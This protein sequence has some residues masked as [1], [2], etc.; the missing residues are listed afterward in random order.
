MFYFDV[1]CIQHILPVLGINEHRLCHAQWPS[2][3]L[4]D[5]SKSH[6]KWSKPTVDLRN[7]REGLP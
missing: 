1:E 3:K 2:P 4:K 5:L 7:V 6:W